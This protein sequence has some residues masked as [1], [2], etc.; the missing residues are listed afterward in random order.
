[1]VNDI[2]LMEEVAEE[3]MQVEPEVTDRPNA[4]I[5]YPYK[6]NLRLSNFVR[7]YHPDGTWSEIAAPT[8]N[9]SRPTPYREQF[10]MRYLKKRGP[11]GGRWFFLTQQAPPPELP[12]R[13][14]VE[15]S[16]RQCPKRLRTIPDLY[17]HVISKHGEE[18]KMY[19]DVLEAMKRKMQAQLEPTVLQ[20]LGIGDVEPG[21][22]VYHCRAEGCP[23]F[24]DSEQGRKLHET[25]GH[26]EG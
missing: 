11:N 5:E 13:C 7:F 24:F 26:K 9:P 16:G 20:A 25:T 10:L 14:F 15:P 3:L 18:S 2:G 8:Y 23:R 4:Q 22:T 6:H 1:M 12:I 21:P 19:A 17:M